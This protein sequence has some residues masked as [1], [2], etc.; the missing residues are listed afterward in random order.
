MLKK[1]KKRRGAVAATAKLGTANGKAA[2]RL[3][4]ETMVQLYAAHRFLPLKAQQ[5]T[6]LR[7]LVPIYFKD[8]L[9]AK[10]YKGLGIDKD[11]TTPWEPG[12]RDGPTS[13]RFAV[14]DYDAT[15]N[16]LTPPAVW[17]KKNCCY[18]RPD[19]GVLSGQDVALFQFHQ[20]SVWATIQNTLDYFESGFGLGRRISWAFEG[21]RLIV[22]P[23][24]G[25]GANAYYDRSSKSL[26]FYYFNGS[27]DNVIYT[28]LSS[29][30]VN[31]EAGH[32]VL[33]G[34]RPYYYEAVT[35]QGAA[36]HE[37]LGDLTALLMAFRNNAFRRHLL[38][39]NKGDLASDG[40]LANLAPEFGRAVSGDHTYLRSALNCKTMADVQDSVDPHQ[41]SQVLTGAMYDILL[42]VYEKQRRA[43]DKDFKAGRKEKKPTDAQALAMTVPRMQTMAIQ[44]LDL[45]PP[46]CLDF[47]DYA[48]AV[49]RTEQVA[50]PTDPK[51]YRAMMLDVFIK[52]GILTD[53]DRKELLK[54]QPVF[55]RP[56]L[57]VY[58]PVE[59]IA[60]S[61][62]G[63]YRFL[64]DNRKQLLIPFNADLR[65]NEV[66]RARKLARDGRS[67]PDQIVVQY[68]WREELELKGKRFG[69]F[70]GETTTMLCGGTMV[71]DQNGNQIHW[72]RQPGSDPLSD[73]PKDEQKQ[74]QKS[75][76]AR[77]KEFLD[78]IAKRIQD[79]SI[80][81]VVG[82]EIGLVERS[83]APYGVRRVDG[84][85]QFELTP[86]FSL[87]GDQCDQDMGD[88]QWQLSF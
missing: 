35:G 18:R 27:D 12:L 51:G 54:P 39:K 15:T 84:R 72:A 41:V 4:R 70:N 31:H 29:D 83:I 21:N 49:L 6:G 38:E 36:F 59:S 30:I 80:S 52:R 7:L 75:G 13:A 50:N 61:A 87:D 45:L 8:P 9:I 77:R 60:A 10:L 16:T 34:L 67:L 3:S 57:E 74:E 76:I 79:G 43:D 85:I 48:L 68:T 81:E 24:A 88:R 20:L 23:H 63:A 2:K 73:E 71:L 65:V 19:G 33:D 32:A 58:H 64:D 82:G 14:V 55:K 56:P 86:H 44:P 69:R 11:F 62:G 17:D 26:Q 47:R 22:L 1:S 42:G 53:K 28:C 46:C 37:F 66:I 78:A 5:E 25:N 40:L